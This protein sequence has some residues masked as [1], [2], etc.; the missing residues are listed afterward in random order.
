MS[1]D[2]D[3]LDAMEKAATPGPWYWS[4]DP[5]GRSIDLSSVDWVVMDFQRW[6]MDAATPCF[7]RNGTLEKA[8]EFGKI[9][10]GREHHASWARELDHPDANLLVAL[11]N[12]YP[13]MSLELRKLR[14]IVG[15]LPKTADGAPVTPEMKLYRM[16]DRA[17]ANPY[18]ISDCGVREYVAQ[19][20][21][22]RTEVTFYS[23]RE[24][25]EAAK[26]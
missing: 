5:E 23:T 2:L 19:M 9:I 10:P 26:K 7:R 6:G 15:K 25:A 17:A 3:K 24:A 18:G 13:A 8:V 11:R 12:A 20:V 21:P 16:V 1:F 14:E 4:L 22:W